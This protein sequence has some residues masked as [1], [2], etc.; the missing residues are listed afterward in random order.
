MTLL[1]SKEGCKR[2]SHNLMF[3]KVHLLYWLRHEKKSKLMFNFCHVWRSFWRYTT[4]SG[5]FQFSWTSFGRIYE[6][7]QFFSSVING[8]HVFGNFSFRKKF[9]MLLIFVFIIIIVFFAFLST[10]YLASLMRGHIMHYR[11]LQKVQLKTFWWP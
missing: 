10:C 1:L 4:Y 8:V 2:V 11:W 5:W 9:K 3:L 7:N 6:P